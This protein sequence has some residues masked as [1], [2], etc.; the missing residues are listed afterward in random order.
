[1]L[2]TAVRSHISRA[3]QVAPVQPLYGAGLRAAVATVLPLLA[4]SHF[5]W[6]QAIWIGLSG[7]NV[8][9]A[10][11]GGPLRRRLIAMS[12]SLFWGAVAASLGAVAG[13][14]GVSAVAGIA[15][16]A[17]GA[18]LARAWGAAATSAG[19]VAIATYV[20]SIGYPSA[21]FHA[22]L[23]RGGAVIAG[24]LFG[25]A[26]ALIFGPIRRYRPGRKA[27]AHAL[28]SLAGVVRNPADAELQAEARHALDAARMMLASLRR[29]LQTELPRGERLL[30]LTEIGDR[31]LDTVSAPIPELADA[32]VA[33][34]SAVDS[35]RSNELPAEIT[36]TTAALLPLIAAMLTTTR[37]LNENLRLIEPGGLD[38]RRNYVEPILHNLRWHSA[39]MRHALRVSVASAAAV[40]MTSAF[41][42]GRGYWLTLTVVIILQ[43][44]TSTTFQKGLQRV[45]GTIAGGILAAVLLS[46]VHSPELMMVLIFAGAALTVA[47]LPLNYGLYSLFL[48]PTF[49]LLAEVGGTDWHLIWL[50]VGNTIGGAGIA[51]LAAWLLWPASER[52]LVGDDLAEALRALAEYARCIGECDD[53]QA[54]SSRRTYLVAF[55]NADAS[56]QR[57]LSESGRAA[58]DT[59]SIDVESFMALLVFTRRFSLALSAIVTGSQ[60]RLR[61]DPLTRLSSQVLSDIASAIQEH[62]PPSP[63][64]D[65]S[66]AWHVAGAERLL[67]PLRSM[68]RA[69]ERLVQ[70]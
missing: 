21:S 27:V 43:P 22:S 33:I 16:L 28:R 66:R 26:L 57:L 39:V 69:A 64:P 10:D 5:G 44:Y 29:G 13:G 47:L 56:L 48:T 58:G 7:F 36:V 50:R 23:L 46:L 70:A 30:V 60:D 59:H 18:G 15:V 11:K 25:M 49:V 24:G 34:A 67:E 9:L 1:M 3:T 40:A 12:S 38:V 52:G 4:G 19:I 62:H 55:Q 32:L 31:I 6:T 14:N 20:L 35:E 8:T 17:F 54:E 68:H 41:H 2:R 61:L 53:Q 42:I 51:Y 65:V 45:G 37:E 63:L